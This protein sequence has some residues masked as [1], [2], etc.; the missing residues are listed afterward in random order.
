MPFGVWT[1]VGPSKYVLDEGAYWRNLANTIG[2]SMC[3]GAAAFLSNYFDHLLLFTALMPRNIFRRE[4][5]CF[6]GEISSMCNLK[7]YATLALRRYYLMKVFAACMYK[8]RYGPTCRLH[9][10]PVFTGRVHGYLQCG[11]VPVNTAHE[12]GSPKLHPHTIRCTYF[13]VQ[14]WCSP[15]H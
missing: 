13:F 1:W 3:G 14:L 2:P 11:Q 9:A 15:D 7:V 4:V 6:E 5:R 10:L 12:R 8:A